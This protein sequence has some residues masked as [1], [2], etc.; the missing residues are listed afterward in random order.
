M[1]HKASEKL[2]TYGKLLLG[3][4]IILIVFAEA[5]LV[6][7][8]LILFTTSGYFENEF[9]IGCWGVV[10]LLLVIAFFLAKKNRIPIG[11]ILIGLGV[12]F[13]INAFYLLNTFTQVYVFY[14]NL[15]ISLWLF[16]DGVL[17]IR[18]GVINNR[19]KQNPGFPTLGDIGK[20]S[21]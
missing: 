10:L 8:D 1:E 15:V 7:I 4:S 19:L 6:F 13:L 5:F 16:I 11:G 21:K 3:I 2:Y 18:S 17:F 20:P 14:F 12:I 9:T